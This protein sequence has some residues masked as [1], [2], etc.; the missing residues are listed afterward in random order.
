[1][2]NGESFFDISEG[3]FG[4]DNDAGASD[5]SWAD[6][7][8]SS[9]ENQETH[10]TSSSVLPQGIDEV[11]NASSSLPV[12]TSQN[13]VLT[14]SQSSFILANT[15]SPMPL[16]NQNAGIQF[17]QQQQQQSNQSQQIITSLP[18]LIGSTAQLVRGPNGQFILTNGPIQVQQSQQTLQPSSVQFPSQQFQ[19]PSQSPIPASSPAINRSLTPASSPLIS[20]S[21]GSIQYATS[22]SDTTSITSSKGYNQPLVAN[23]GNTNVNVLN[24]Q[25][26]LLARNIQVQG[27]QILQN[28]GVV[29]GQ[30][31]V[32][33]LQGH[34]QTAML[35]GQLQGQT[36]VLQGH[37]GQT[38]L[39]QGQQGQT[40][41][42]HGQG[43]NIVNTQNTVI[44]NPNVVNLNVAHVLCNNPALQNQQG[45]TVQQGQNIQGTLI[46]TADGKSII[47]P[48]QLLQSG[49]PI[50]LQNLQQVFQPQLNTSGANVI[51]GSSASGT[52][53]LQGAS[54]LG[55]NV[56]LGS[57]GNVIRMANNTSIAG[58]DKNMGA[59]HIIGVNSQGQQVLIQRAQAQQQNIMVRTLT[60]QNLH[61]QQPTS[62]TTSTS[63]YQASQGSQVMQQPL[64]VTSQQPGIQLQRIITP[65][66]QPVIPGQQ[67]QTVKVIGQNPAGVLSIN[68]PQNIS[69]QNL[70][71]NPQVQTVQLVQQQVQ[72]ATIG[73]KSDDSSGSQA[74][75]VIQ[76]ASTDS[77]LK[78]LSFVTKTVSQQGNLIHTSTGLQHSD[79]ASTQPL[80]SSVQNVFSQALS[81][82]PQASITSSITPA[83]TS[84]SQTVLSQPIFSTTQQIPH[85]V[86]SVVT[87]QPS[88]DTKPP[89]LLQQTT[90]QARNNAPKLQTIQLTPETQQKLQL[91]QAELKTLLSLKHLTAEQMKRQKELVD[92]QKG[93]LQ[94]CAQQ[95]KLQVAQP[96]IGQ[97]Q[98]SFTTQNQVIIKTE[99]QAI[100]PPMIGEPPT[101]TVPQQ[102]S[103]VTSLTQGVAQTNAAVPNASPL[104]QA[105][106]SSSTSIRPALS[107]AQNLVQ[108]KVATTQSTIQIGQPVTAMTGVPKPVGANLSLGTSTVKAGPQQVAVPTQIKIANHVLQ[109]NLTPEQKNKVEG[110]LARMTPEQQQQQITMF[111]KLQQQQQLQAQVQ[112]QKAHQ[113][114]LQQQGK[115]P[116]PVQTLTGAATRPAS[117]VGPVL[118]QQG[119][120][121]NKLVAVAS[122]PKDK[123]IHQQL[124]KDQENALRPDTRTPFR[125][126]RDMTRRLLR[127]HVFQWKEPPEKLVKKDEEM[128]ENCAEGLMRKNTAMFEKFRLLLMK[129]SMREKSTAETVMIKRLLNDD[130][131]ETINREK[132]LILEDPAS[133]KPMPLHLLRKSEK[134]AVKEEMEEQKPVVVKQEPPTEQVPPEN[135]PSSPFVSIKE[136]ES[137]SRPTTPKFKLI[138][139]NDGQKLTSSTCITE[140]GDS[141]TNTYLAEQSSTDSY[142]DNNS[143]K[144]SLGS[145]SPLLGNIENK[146]N[147]DITMEDNTA[148]RWSDISND[149]KPFAS[150]METDS[151]DVSQMSYMNYP[152]GKMEMEGTDSNLYSDSA[153]TVHNLISSEDT[154]NYSNQNTFHSSPP[155]SSQPIS[156]TSSNA[157]YHQDRSKN[158]TFRESFSGLEDS[159]KSMESSVSSYPGSACAQ[160]EPISSD[161]GDEEENVSQ[162]VPGKSEPY[163]ISIG[164]HTMKYSGDSQSYSQTENLHKSNRTTSGNVIEITGNDTMT[165]ESSSSSDSDS[166]SE[167]SSGKEEDN[168]TNYQVQSA[169]DSI[170]QFNDNASSSSTYHMDQSDFFNHDYD[171][172]QSEESAINSPQSYEQQEN[173]DQTDTTSMEDDL[174]AAVK[175]IL[176]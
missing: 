140:D 23:V 66:G 52:G 162:Y 159:Q 59:T 65:A 151:A 87:P 135:K 63:H 26:Q 119:S 111:L 142:C 18:N 98:A 20:K 156:F 172:S 128:F 16:A 36:A 81:V 13:N 170:L 106:S 94:K 53:M 133:F 93:I 107:T 132:K 88:S 38:A 157:L 46:Q 101:G 117:G 60:P 152:D 90:L 121:D 92:L 4:N 68:L 2:D 97:P 114:K 163:S 48:S 74:Q 146:P 10:Q 82:T 174:D 139:R 104:L 41:M 30:G 165:I 61:L 112:A 123:L 99:P 173:G 5:F 134:A 108:S 100:P 19:A 95:H 12:L 64:L 166:D 164:K 160:Y 120:S 24:A 27:Q 168:E 31:H 105:L 62:N 80:A 57:I 47:I 51:Q 124:S 131:K 69:F 158:S 116:T 171:A 22:S 21:V 141:D 176:M 35:Q 175:S 55:N 137:N 28:S 3:F 102:I 73:V 96:M 136:E 79:Q 118:I 91:I 45:G 6:E 84:Q 11:N 144:G 7:F 58:Q 33:Y 34:G 125:D 50:N 147:D 17:V 148:T 143:D 39:L 44:Q 54:V 85:V 49:Q 43:Q 153:E 70:Q 42:L 145:R 150:Y 103:G 129:E 167:V 25:Q 32:S 37:T 113:A 15:A 130:L 161:E 169:I 109:L 138:I 154:V 1:M 89:S 67:N 83:T 71:Q 40:A 127:N 72:R 115:I 122:I 76:V 9:S 8:I 75:Q 86:P 78:T 149:E 77:S 14:T 126:R 56:T 110:Y 155:S 29:Q